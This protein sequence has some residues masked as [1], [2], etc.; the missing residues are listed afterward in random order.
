MKSALSLSHLT[1]STT[2]TAIFCHYW[3]PSFPSVSVDYRDDIAECKYQG[4]GHAEEI[5]VSN[6][7][8]SYLTAV[9]EP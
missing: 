8:A 9:P 2:M 6:G 1:E 3:I 7:R 5:V 4:S